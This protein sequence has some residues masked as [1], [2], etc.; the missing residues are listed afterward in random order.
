MNLMLECLTYC[1][2]T[3]AITAGIF[4]F[5]PYCQWLLS[6]WDLYWQSSTWLSLRPQIVGEPTLIL[7]ARTLKYHCASSCAII[8][9]TL[10][11]LNSSLRNH[12]KAKSVPN[13]VNSEDVQ[14]LSFLELSIDL[15]VLTAL[16]GKLQDT[17]VFPVFTHLTSLS[18]T[19]IALEEDPIKIFVG[20]I[21]CYLFF[22]IR[23]E[24][25][26]DLI[27][28]EYIFSYHFWQMILV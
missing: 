14:F 13:L 6:P 4:T 8:R 2:P 9:C 17:E 19:N 11:G 21:G 7:E 12:S 27:N 20:N 3:V 15:G 24:K 10:T 16:L 22:R 18:E 23:F 28:S 25:L 1:T 5:I 26:I